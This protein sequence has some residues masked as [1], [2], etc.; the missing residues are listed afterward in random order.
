M[1]ASVAKPKQQQRSWGDF[2]LDWRP[3]LTA[4]FVAVVLAVA[5]MKLAHDYAG[6]DPPAPVASVLNALNDFIF[7]D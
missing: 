5:G 2:L 7:G 4:F 6:W 3:W 1:R